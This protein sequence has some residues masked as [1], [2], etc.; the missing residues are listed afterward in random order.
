MKN[1]IKEY[2]KKLIEDRFY[3]DCIEELENEDFEDWKD[4]I[5]ECVWDEFEFD[6]EVE[7][8]NW[9][10]IEEMFDELKEDY[11]EGKKDDYENECELRRDYYNS[12]GV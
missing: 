7:L 3:E 6:I 11:L 4:Y 9:D 8:E 1:E 12:L 5:G 10:E 2:I